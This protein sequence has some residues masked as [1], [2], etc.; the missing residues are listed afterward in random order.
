MP[1][2]W[3]VELQLQCQHTKGSASHCTGNRDVLHVQSISHWAPSCIGPYSQAVKL[4]GLV[5]LAGQIGL[6]PPTMQL[7][8]TLSAQVEQSFKSCQVKTI[9]VDMPPA[10]NDLLSGCIQ[11]IAPL[12]ISILCELEK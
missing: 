10:L 12:V 4:P 2:T 11:I 6:H 5:F 9:L 8:P 1:L 3:H 7:L